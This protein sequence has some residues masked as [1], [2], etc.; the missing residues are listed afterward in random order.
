MCI[1]DRGKDYQVDTGFIVFNDRTYP[2]FIALLDEL[3]VAWQ[4]SAMSFSVHCEKTGLEYNGT[5]LNRL[6]A[7]R[8]NL[9]KPYFYQMIRDILRFNKS[10][11]ELLEA[12]SEVKLGDYLRA[13]R[14][15]QKFI[16]YYIIPMGSAIWSTD[17]VQMLDFPARF[18]VRFFHHHGM[19]TV[20][21]RPQWRTVTNGSASYVAALTEPFKHRIQLKTPIE[22]VRRTENSVYV[23]PKHGEEIALSLIHI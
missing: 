6:F 15:C 10:A 19:L 18:F 13:G 5:T 22:S 1:R 23:K 20:N 17:A 9:F 11:L 2:N 16:D 14:Y 7:Q 3:K 12:G 4:P 21:N 8:S